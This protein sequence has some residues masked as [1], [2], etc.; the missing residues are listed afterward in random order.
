MI[1][2]EDLPECPAATAI[3]LVGGK[4]KLLIIRGLLKRPM[5]FNELKRELSGISHKVLASSLR[6][7]ED[8]GIITRK[9]YPTKPQKVEYHLSGLGETLRPLL[10]EME[11]WGKFYK[12]RID[13][14]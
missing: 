3:E 6:S 9:V 14:L 4:W 10:L 1:K 7:M 2:R 12:S 11:S 8:D 13:V 5:R